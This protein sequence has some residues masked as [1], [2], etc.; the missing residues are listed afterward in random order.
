M[1]I[2]C[3]DR[4]FMLSAPTA[5]A[6]RDWV[7][8]IE[9]ARVGAGA[10][11]AM[12]SS[13]P[14]EAALELGAALPDTLPNRRSSDDLSGQVIV[15]LAVPTAEGTCD[16]ECV[17]AR[18]HAADAIKTALEAVLFGMGAELAVIVGAIAV[19][20]GPLIA[21]DG[22]GAMAAA[23]AQLASIG[24]GEG[25]GDEGGD[26]TSGERGSTGAGG[27]DIDLSLALCYG[28]QAMPAQAAADGGAAHVEFVALAA[29]CGDKPTTALSLAS[30]RRLSE[31]PKEPPKLSAG[32]LQ[33]MLQ[34]A[35]AS[36]LKNQLRPP[37]LAKSLQRGA[38]A[39]ARGAMAGRGG[40]A[41]GTM[42]RVS[43]QGS[44]KQIDVSS[45]RQALE[46]LPSIRRGDKKL[47][48]AAP[49]DG[50]PSLLQLY[51]FMQSEEA[52]DLVEE[53]DDA[54]GE[55]LTPHGAPSTPKPAPQ[56]YPTPAPPKELG[57]RP[58]SAP[59]GGDGVR[60]S[61]SLAFVQE[62][63][64][65]NYARSG[66]GQVEQIAQVVGK[67]LDP[68][69][70]AAAKGAGGGGG[71]GDGR[72]SK[73]DK[74]PAAGGRG[75][76]R[77]STPRDKAFDDSDV[78][79]DGDDGGGG[80]GDGGGPSGMSAFRAGWTTKQLRAIRQVVSLNK[81]RFQEE[82]FDL[83]LTY[84][85]PRIIAMGFPSEDTESMYR[86]P[87]KEVQ[88]FFETR[89]HD[90]YKV[91]NLCGER[92]YEPNVFNNRVACYPFEDHNAPA[93]Q[94]I[95]DTMTDMSRWLDDHPKNVVAV[96][97]KAGKGRTGIMVCCLL[98]WRGYFATMGQALEFYAKMRTDDMDGVTIP[99]QRRFVLYFEHWRTRP[100]CCLD[101]SPEGAP[102]MRLKY[103]RL[104]PAPK[105]VTPRDLYFVVT[106][107]GGRCWRGERLN[108]S[109]ELAI[110]TSIVGLGLP[111]RKPS[112]EWDWSGLAR[113]PL[114]LPKGGVVRGDVRVEVMQKDKRLFRFWFHTAFLENGHLRLTK[115][116][117]DGPHKD[118][119]CKHYEEDFAAELY[120]DPNPTID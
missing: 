16:E 100:G 82:G 94:M 116:E 42:R 51:Q 90:H 83:D 117:L 91:Y 29:R 10:K 31:R 102:S 103:L 65:D 18:S 57:T 47:P 33:P 62:M 77:A 88:A 30:G 115:A 64:K 59:G 23:C 11:P 97:C 105:G 80:D 69:V 27:A 41:P 46:R 20:R 24:G 107:S 119:K 81:K 71:G 70:A 79:D 43:M 1:E 85:T 93:L 34:D 106:Q 25:G 56:A 84:I 3:R 96:H 72:P 95:E 78:D 39:T 99:S 108:D 74:K 12:L 15:T 109:R 111:G 63:K 73:S 52:E 76:D 75:G 6:A 114:D 40:G 110:K 17:K 58:A 37:A 112:L 26:A 8:V 67:E 32:H 66:T 120:F 2:R 38:A 104:E 22:A 19:E 35:L 48:P 92:T 7:A 21:D 44:V 53:I 54:D 68:A 45:A 118:R 14:S 98:Y 113:A 13:T 55:P 89:H 50:G 86:N 61:V 60:D 101:V 4:N 87:R 5:Q 36:A 49:A 9:E 28:L